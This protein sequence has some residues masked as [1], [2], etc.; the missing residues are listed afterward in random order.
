M[1]SRTGR[2]PPSQ[3][4]APSV[5][6]VSQ[7]SAARRQGSQPAG[8]QTPGS[9]NDTVFRHAPPQA[10]RTVSKQYG[11]LKQRPGRRRSAASASWEEMDYDCHSE[12]HDD[13]SGY[14][15]SCDGAGTTGQQRHRVR[16]LPSMHEGAEGSTSASS[17]RSRL[18]G[19][20]VDDAWA[21]AAKAE[22]GLNAVFD[23]YCERL[24]DVAHTVAAGGGGPS[25]MARRVVADNI[26]M[27]RIT[28]GT[29]IHGVSLTLTRACLIA[30]SR[31]APV[32]RDSVVAARAQSY[33]AMAIPL[34][35]N[36]QR[37]RTPRQVRRAIAV[38][39]ALLHR[40]GQSA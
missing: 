28:R 4:D 9:F 11:G 23:C 12:E 37:T 18:G 5:H 20:V 7:A 22:G 8:A 17:A 19:P 15:T 24:V 34:A 35:A 21:L 36:W 27:L 1:S 38:L 33:Y 13:V 32:Q 31:N 26:V 29:P 10:R 16:E 14:D 39:T 30:A 2:L 6:A 40:L 3:R 25:A